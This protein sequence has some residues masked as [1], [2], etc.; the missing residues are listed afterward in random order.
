MEKFEDGSPRVDPRVDPF[1]TLVLTTGFVFVLWVLAL[2]PLLFSLPL[3]FPPLPTQKGLVD[4]TC[5]SL[6]QVYVV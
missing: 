1:G 3:D 4:L 6:L 5:I 2:L